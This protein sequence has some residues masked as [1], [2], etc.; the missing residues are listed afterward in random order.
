MLKGAGHSL[1]GVF[2]L[3]GVAGGLPG[4][5]VQP[6]ARQAEQSPA[7]QPKG[8][9]QDVG[10]GT[11]Q[12]AELFVPGGAEEKA[13]TAAKATKA[14]RL[15]PVIQ[16][17]LNVGMKAAAGAI[18]TRG[19]AAVQHGDVKTAAELGAA[20][21]I[22]EEFVGPLVRGFNERLPARLVNSLIRPGLKDFNLG[23]NPGAG[24]AGEGIAAAT[25]DGLAQKIVAKKRMIGAAIDTALQ[26]PEIASKTTD[27]EPLISKPINDAI[28]EAT[29]SGNQALVTRLYSLR[30]ALTGEFGVDAERKVVRTGDR[31]LRLDPYSTNQLKR[32]VG[33]QTRWENPVAE[34]YSEVL[35]SARVRIYHNLDSA[36]DAAAPGVESLNQ[37]YGNLL[38]AE[39][40]L[41]KATKLAQRKIVFGL[42]DVAVGAAAGAFGGREGSVSDGIASGLVAI[43]GRHVLASTAGKTVGAQLLRKTP[44]AVD[45][46]AKIGRAGYLVS[47]QDQQSSR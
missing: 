35:N 19:V 16:R 30:D 40:S 15:S 21:P 31:P 41:E 24:V 42:G 38:S 37:R 13:A 1:A 10:K 12:V 46:A 8:L 27:V 23:K 2:S 9:A 6:Y 4:M 5:V 36:I 44:S 26:K 39:K 3:L 17:W 34:P 47:T 7:L 45:A 11:E 33:R 18:T 28:A 14:I 32:E 22:A 25:V 29:K 43:A 20:G